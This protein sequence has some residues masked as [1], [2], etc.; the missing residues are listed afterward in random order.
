MNF[1][2]WLFVFSFTDNIANLCCCDLFNGSG[3]NEKNSWG[4]GSGN[5]GGQILPTCTKGTR[6]WW[7]NYRLWKKENGEHCREESHVWRKTEECQVGSE[8]KTLQM[9]QVFVRLHEEG[10]VGKPS[11]FQM[12]SL[13]QEFQI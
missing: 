4:W 9:F 6:K 10:T 1:C 11:M 2:S 13:Q 3:R 7:G 8:R 12:W 5:Q